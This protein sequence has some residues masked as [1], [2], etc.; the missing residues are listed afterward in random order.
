MNNIFYL[1]GILYFIV[2]V[3]NFLF[4]D[5]KNRAELN[6]ES[7]FSKIKE[8]QNVKKPEKNSPR[9]FLSYLFFFWTYVGCVGDFPEKFFLVI[10]FTIQL[11]YIVFLIL[12]TIKVFINGFKEFK[13]EQSLEQYLEE[14]ETQEDE[15][16]N[17]YY[18]TIK[19]NI[20]ITKILYF[21]E[22]LIIGNILIIH[23]FIL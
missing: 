6:S 15:Q 18:K 16:E 13:R 21:F 4:Y 17:E 14:D 10:N 3:Y 22:I 23:F 11:I 2:S 8:N 1:I 9:V 7:E 5:K 19:R 20:P 12:I